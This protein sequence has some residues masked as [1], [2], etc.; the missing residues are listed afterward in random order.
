MV[1]FDI[2]GDLW[3]TIGDRTYVGRR[4]RI[5]R[6]EQYRQRRQDD[7]ERGET[8]ECERFLS[9]VPVLTS[10]EIAGAGQSPAALVGTDPRHLE[11]E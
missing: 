6:G 9:T 3:G 7:G 11:A 10:A 2:S 4:A 5:L 1:G 8:R